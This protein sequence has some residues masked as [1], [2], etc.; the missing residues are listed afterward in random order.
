MM[1]IE[2]TVEES[3]EEEARKAKETAVEK[4]KAGD[5]VGA[6]EFAAKAKDLDPKLGGLLRLSAVLDVQI[7]FAKKINGELTDWYAV[8]AVDPTAD[9]E[10]I[11]NGYKKLVFDIIYDVD[12]T[13]GYDEANKILAEAWNCM[14]SERRKKAYDRSRKINIS[15]QNGG[16]RDELVMSPPLVEK[17]K[18]TIKV[19][20]D[21]WASA[22]ETNP[23]HCEIVPASDFLKFDKERVGE[24]QVWAAYDDDGM[25]RYYAMIHSIVSREPMTL[26]VSWLDAMNGDEPVTVK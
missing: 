15:L 4:H 3:F 21:R 11:L 9:H 20:L 5:L 10:T 23:I 8:L 13:V 19:S 17:P 14:F 24:N 16:R 7:A 22:E 12:D 2:R 25:P 18:S 26:C 1:P 6:K